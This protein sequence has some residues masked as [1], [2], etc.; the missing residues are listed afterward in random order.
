M[1]DSN[2]VAVAL[3]KNEEGKY[4]LIRLTNYEEHKTEWC[5]IAGHVKQGETIK[6]A[7]IREAKEE[8][9]VKIEPVTQIAEWEQDIPG[10]TAVWW[11]VKITSG[12]IKPNEEIAEWGYFSKDESKNLKLWPATRKFF[13]KFI[14]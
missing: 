2:R 14:W 7:L 3:I 8:L 10:E 12:Q 1:N 11:E 4:L 6:E 9:D 5:P 13:E